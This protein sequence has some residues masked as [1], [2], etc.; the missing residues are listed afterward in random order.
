LY[1]GDF[2]QIDINSV[3]TPVTHQIM[4]AYR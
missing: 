2:L 3:N 1:M 4:D